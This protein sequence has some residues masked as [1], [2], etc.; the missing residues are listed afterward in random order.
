MQYINHSSQLELNESFLSILSNQVESPE[1]TPQSPQLDSDDIVE[2]GYFEPLYSDRN[3]RRSRNQRIPTAKNIFEMEPSK[4]EI[5]EQKLLRQK[6]PDPPQQKRKRKSK[7]QEAEDLFNPN[8]KPKNIGEFIRES[9]V[10]EFLPPIDIT[11]KENLTIEINEPIEDPVLHEELAIAELVAAKHNSDLKLDIDYGLNLVFNNDIESEYIRSLEVNPSAYDLTDSGYRCP[12]NN[13]YN[14]ELFIQRRLFSVLEHLQFSDP[15]FL[16][17]H[18][19]V[20]QELK[21]IDHTKLINDD[22]NSLDLLKNFIYQDF[23]QNTTTS[24]LFRN[25]RIELNQLEKLFSLK[26]H[27]RLQNYLVISYL[28]F[29]EPKLI[30]DRSRTVE[31]LHPI[32]KRHLFR[33]STIKSCFNA[34]GI[35]FF[36]D[37]LSF[38]VI[39]PYIGNL[40][41]DRHA[42]RLKILKKE[43]DLENR[44]R[45][46][47]TINLDDLWF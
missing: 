27:R 47:E 9:L 16:S 12:I 22:D 8:A 34:C 41:E 45:R 18:L 17:R 43:K 23:I 14:K 42:A 32:F 5:E 26:R 33:K 2:F 6:T 7:K 30:S 44:K 37:Y 25:K 24:K 3:L 13:I 11:Q 10:E 19:P 29:N 1:Y 20:H 21:N 36:D 38:N 39:K 28:I 40:T 31:S 4:R 15:A 46:K 35:G